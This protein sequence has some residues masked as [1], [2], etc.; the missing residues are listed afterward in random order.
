MSVDLAMSGEDETAASGRRRSGLHTDE[1]VMP[2]QL[3]GRL[4]WTGGRQVDRRLLD[5]PGERGVLHRDTGER[6]REDRAA[7]DR[8]TPLMPLDD[9]PTNHYLMHFLSSPS[10][11][12]T[13]TALCLLAGIAA[14]AVPRRRFLVLA[15]R[16]RR[17]RRRRTHAG[18]LALDHALAQRGAT[19]SG[20]DGAATLGRRPGGV[21]RR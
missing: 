17:G 4:H 1:A 14:L 3:V 10:T 7:P 12:A 15:T 8:K 18:A 2:Q 20:T 11:V 21:D 16:G 6:T 9:R 19:R 5:E 13:F